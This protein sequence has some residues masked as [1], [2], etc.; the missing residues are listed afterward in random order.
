MFIPFL[1]IYLLNQ[2]NGNSSL[3]LSLRGAVRRRSNL[4][5]EEIASLLRGSQ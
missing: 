2:T 1:A 4:I 5:V 3:D